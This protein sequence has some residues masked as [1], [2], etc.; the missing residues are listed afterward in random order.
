MPARVNPSLRWLVC[1]AILAFTADAR[2]DAPDGGAAR[3]PAAK[4]G[5]A[6]PAEIKPSETALATPDQ[7]A[8]PQRRGADA[9]LGPDD[10]AVRYYASRNET[11][12]MNAEIERLK[13]LYP[14]WQPS[15][16]PYDAAPTGVEDETDLWNL[17]TADKMD[18][19]DAAIEAR[20]A[21]EHG[22]QPS[23]DLAQKIRHKTARLKIEDYLKQGR[24]LD[25]VD[26]VHN[27]D[28]TADADVDI[29]WAVAEAFAHT[30]QTAE[31]QRIYKSILTANKVPAE[32]LAT[33]QKAMGNMRMADVEPLIAMGSPSAGGPNE[34]APIQLDITRARVSAY[35]HNERDQDV[36]EADLRAFGEFARA[37]ADPNQAGLMGWYAYGHK[38]YRN[39]L[40][41]FKL[42][43]THGG[44]AM[45]AHGLAHSLRA[46]GYPREVEEVAYAW[47]EPLINNAVL[48]ID[49]LETDLT[50]EVPPYIEPERLARYADE[51]LKLASGEGA[52]ALAWYSYNSCQFDIALAW[53]ERANA[54]AP[55]EATAYGYALTLR[56][57]HRRKEFFEVVNRY[58]GLF[59]KVVSLVF[60]D[61]SYHPPT[62]CDVKRAARV[63]APAQIIGGVP[64][65]APASLQPADIAAASEMDAKRRA[66]FQATARRADR[67]PALARTDFPTL[68]DPENN[69][70][71]AALGQA[72][73]PVFAT[74][75]GAAP[76]EIP[77]VARRVPGVGPM[78]YERYGFALL[79][80]YN[81]QTTAS[82]P[83]SALSAPA[84]TPWSQ[85][86]SEFGP[87][88]AALQFAPGLRFSP[89]PAT[90]LLRPSLTP[91]PEA[92][93][94]SLAPPV[95]YSN[96]PPVAN[97]NS[98]GSQ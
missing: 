70:R 11:Q 31:A 79:P 6:R 64:V 84:G 43:L 30:K 71:F 13:R 16:D 7:V 68:V 60:P 87:V 92:L 9:A 10:S 22:W 24:W 38:D 26:Y 94:P 85:Q 48:F 32:R 53:F 76:P 82:A 25:I 39:A 73:A 36:P 29:L 4:S 18:E 83:H 78:P 62:P 14:G 1:A 52:Q 54:W 93:P 28:A 90:D 72:F 45:V 57:L 23:A 75:E 77:L 27:G 46:L 35:L 80:A 49:I 40:E 89:P 2:A 21:A 69:L 55:K 59:P 37:S 86:M 66:Q 88:A 50:R 33:I 58:D 47:R 95:A 20:K 61:N 8:D 63:D 97:A 51:T 96:P 34:F 5:E 19:L 15:K 17:F 98:Y 74:A 3:A 91:S 81:G 12:R 44:G 67:M 56:R 42:S 41:W 65:P